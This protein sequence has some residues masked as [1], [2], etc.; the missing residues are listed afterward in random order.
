VSAPDVSAP[1]GESPRA[2]RARVDGVTLCVFGSRGVTDWGACVRALTRALNT[3]G[4][5]SVGAVVSGMCEDSPDMLGVHIAERYGYPLT[6]MPA[7]WDDL[8]APGAVVRRRRDGTPF[9]VRAGYAR[10]TRM[11][12][13]LAAADGLAVGLWDGRSG[14]TQHM[15]AECRRLG[16]RGLLLTVR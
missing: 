5:R 14:G 6:P 11:A 2:A 8:G 15:T 4:V 10:N 1:D 9:N 3:H 13:H 12:E 16:V 7:A